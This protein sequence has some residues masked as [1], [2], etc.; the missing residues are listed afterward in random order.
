VGAIF[1]LA[2]ILNEILHGGDAI[3]DD[4]YSLLRNPVAS[5]IPKWW[6]IHF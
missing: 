6:T 1:E 4:L 5:T 2:G 3:E